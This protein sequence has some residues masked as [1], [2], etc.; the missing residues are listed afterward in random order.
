[1][2]SL[3]V[4]SQNSLSSRRPNLRHNFLLCLWVVGLLAWLEFLRLLIKIDINWWL[5]GLFHLMAAL[6]VMRRAIL[7]IWS[8]RGWMRRS[9]LQSV[10]QNSIP[11]I[12]HSLLQSS[13]CCLSLTRARWW[14]SSGPLSWLFPSV[15]DWGREKSST[16]NDFSFANVRSLVPEPFQTELY[17]HFNPSMPQLFVSIHLT[18]EC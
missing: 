5:C 16:S 18:H 7:I 13:Q 11:D 15:G 1:M 14:S 2:L 12:P 17:S 4:E 9:G 8:H 3:R 10:W 6:S